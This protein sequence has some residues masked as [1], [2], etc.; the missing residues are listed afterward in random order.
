MADF[1]IAN[2]EAAAKSYVDATKQLKGT[3][4]PTVDDFTKTV[5][6]IGEMRTLYLPHVD[7][8]P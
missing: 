1:T 2:L 4:T 6:K 3:F 5:C 7:K 8:L